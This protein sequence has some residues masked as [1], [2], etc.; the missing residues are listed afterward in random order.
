[1]RQF[2]KSILILCIVSGNMLY[3]YADRGVRRKA[4]NKVVLN[5]NTNYNFRN[6]LNTNLNSGMKFN[7]YSLIEADCESTYV[8]GLLVS[9]YQKGN[10]VYL[11]PNKQKTVTPEIKQTFS[12]SKL[13]IK[14]KS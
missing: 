9:T 7:D 1:M 8:S 13:V 5:I 3:L 10:V 14:S 4:K 12:G 2:T 6:S 11:L